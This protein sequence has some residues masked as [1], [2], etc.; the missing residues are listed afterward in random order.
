MAPDMTTFLTIRAGQAVGGAMTLATGLALIY[1]AFP[2]EETGRALGI[3]VAGIFSASR[4]D[5]FWAACSFRCGAGGSCSRR[6]MVPFVVA[7]AVCL[8]N[9]DWRLS[10][11]PGERFDWSGA[12]TSTLAIGLFV[13]GSAHVDGLLGRWCLFASVLCFAAFWS[14]NTAPRRRCC[15]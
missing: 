7:L 6:G 13:W 11:V 1:D 10:P 15:N 14:W 5:R 2:M 4:P 12:A 9:L 8:R 3:S